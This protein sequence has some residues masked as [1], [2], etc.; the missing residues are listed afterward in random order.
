MSQVF[1]TDNECDEIISL[2]TKLKTHHSSEWWM[3]D[4]TS[5]F[6]WHIEKNEETKWIFDRLTLF[7]SKNTNFKVLKDIDMIH[8]Q[9]VKQGHGFE[10]HID[11]HSEYNIG[12][13]L[14]IDYEGG[15]LICH[16]YKLYIPKIKGLIYSF[17]GTQLHEVKKVLSGERWSLIA[18]LDNTIIE[19]KKGLI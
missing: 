2:S 6:A 1:F 8:L 13:C 10:P 14:N 12:V 18:F 17:Y 3:G 19:R 5:Y 15:E 4:K 7:L 9:N 16:D 11:K